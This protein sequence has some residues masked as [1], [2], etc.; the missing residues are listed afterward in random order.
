MS[1]KD[2]RIRLYKKDFNS[3]VIGHVKNE[4]VSLCR[5]KYVLELDHDDEI[6]PDVLKDATTV[7]EK[8]PEVG[9]VYMDFINIY[10][11]GTNFKY[12][13]FL[14]KGYAGYYCQKYKDQWVYVYMTPN[15]N[16]VTLSHLTCCPNHPRIWRRNFLNKIGNYSELLPICDDFEIL[17]RT[18]LNTKVAKIPKLA[19]VQY[20]NK[21]NNNFSLIRNKEINRIGPYWIA[22]H[23]CDKYNIDEVMKKKN[24]FED[25]FH[26]FYH[27]RIWLRKDGY[28]HVYDNLNINLDYVKQF[29][30]WGLK[31]LQYHRI[32]M[33]YKNKKNDFLLLDNKHS[34][35]EIQSIL[36]KNNM[37][38][39]KYYCL[40]N[41][42]KDE[43]I[44]YFLRLYKSCEKYEIID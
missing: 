21:D 44:Q 23:Y 8:H 19:Y 33:L 36:H 14:C 41:T 24:A 2:K 16:N 40:P 3:G 38:R 5:G 28:K 10:E 18:C 15:I 43:F 29:M 39:M 35:E 12:T 34:H 13:D 4:A 20:M 1:K 27:T 32:K 17:L 9:F 31:P 11:D 25:V 42:S 22:P 7:F 6:L 26:K 30:I 37:T